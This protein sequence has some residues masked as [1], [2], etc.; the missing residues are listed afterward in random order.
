MINRRQFILSGSG[1]LMLT[2]TPQAFATSTKES[3]NNALSETRRSKKQ[4]FFDK[5]G[6][7]FI[8]RS[9]S[10]TAWLKLSHIIEEPECENLEQF[11]LVFKSKNINLKDDLY[12]STHLSSLKTETMKIEPSQ[13]LAGHYIAT[14]NLLSV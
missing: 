3:S 1:A 5:L 11:T 7:S 6:D 14:F 2:I 8:M 13:T 9:H 12:S 4:S 10:Q